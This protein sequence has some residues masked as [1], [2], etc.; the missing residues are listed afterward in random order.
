M[1]IKVRNGI[2]TS[3]AHMAVRMEP[4]VELGRKAAMVELGEEGGMEALS[5]TPCSKELFLARS[6][7]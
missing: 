1:D 6:R 4:M 7:E 3:Q 2:A 5:F